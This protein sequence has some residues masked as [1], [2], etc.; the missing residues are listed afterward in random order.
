MENYN[1]G[2]PIIDAIQF[3]ANK[4]RDNIAKSIRRDDKNVTE[5]SE[6]QNFDSDKIKLKSTEEQD[7]NIS[8]TEN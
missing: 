3:R 7:H 6:H 5:N 4:I 8:K 2:R 1:T